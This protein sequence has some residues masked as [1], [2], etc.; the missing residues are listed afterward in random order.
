MKKHELNEPLVKKNQR[1]Q[2]VVF[3]R[4]YLV[5]YGYMRPCRD[6]DNRLWP[7][8]SKALHQFQIFYRLEPTKDLTLQ[9]LKLMRRRRCSMPDF[10]PGEAGGP[11][12]EDSDPF[13]FASSKWNNNIDLKW[14]FKSGTADMTGEATVIQQAFD[15]WAGY[16]PITFTNTPDEDEA[17]IMVSWEVGDHGDGFPF[18]G[19]G[20]ILAHAFYPEDGRIHFDDSEDWNIDLLLATALH[21]IGHTLGLKHSGSDDAVMYAYV[22]ED[23][24]SLHEFDIRGIKSLYPRTYYSNSVDFVRTHLWGLKTKGGS[25]AVTVD[26]GRSVRI[27]AWGQVTMVDPLSG[28][29]RDNLYAV[30][31]FEVDG[32]RPSSYVYGGDHLG[33]DGAPCNVYTGAWVGRAQRVTF[34]MSA[35]HTDD[36]DVF[37]VGNIMILG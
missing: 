10:E 18:D 32:Q 14:F 5:R 24:H 4:K 28:F 7:H 25:D 21:E 17:D 1:N 27:V 9:T 8:V 29:D 19:E 31:V 37:G 33:S 20:S 16:I 11:G 36:L 35:I 2:L 34:R 13:V 6:P 15:V 22:D 23:R 26:L 30:D 3:A 12:I